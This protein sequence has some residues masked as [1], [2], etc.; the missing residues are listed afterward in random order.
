MKG[1]EIVIGV[2]VA[3]G[4][5]LLIF[6][7]YMN[8][9]PVIEDARTT[10]GL[11]AHL[12]KP[13]SNGDAGTTPVK[14]KVPSK[15]KKTS[16]PKNTSVQPPKVEAESKDSGASAGASATPKEQPKGSVNVVDP[17]KTQGTQEVK[18]APAEAADP[19]AP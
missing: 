15:T 10:R 12:S 5:G 13:G 1:N 18:Q 2:G 17:S 6:Y 4:L 14:T 8:K 11:P 9:T 3:L 19:A 7:L 16:A